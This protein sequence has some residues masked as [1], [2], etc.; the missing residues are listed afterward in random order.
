MLVMWR[1]P[2][3]DQT[4]VAVEAAQRGRARLVFDLDDL[5]IEPDLARHDLLDALRTER[6]TETQ[7]R[8]HYTRMRE[9]VEQATF[10]TASTNELAR[11]MRR[12]CKPTL[13]VPNGFDEATL[14]RSRSAVR[15]RRQA[16][17]D[18]LLR[19]GYAAG[20]RTHQRDFAQCVEAVGRILR[21]RPHCRLVLFYSHIDTFPV[22]DPGEFPALTGLELQ[23]EWR[24]TVPLDTM[25]DEM[26]RFDVNLAPLEAGNPFCEAKSELKF[27][28][29]ALVDVPTITA[30]TGPF[31]RAIDDGRTGCLAAT[32]D[33]WYAALARLLDDPALRRRMA[34]AAYLDVLY[35]N[36]PERRVELIASL[37]EQVR[38]DAPAARAFALDLQ[39]AARPRTPPVLPETTTLFA[40]DALGDAEVT[41]IVPLYN[42]AQYVEEALESVRMQSLAPLDLIVI[43][44]TSTDNS[45]DVARAWL[46]RN[47]AR[48][49]RVLL[50]RNAANAG[51]GVTRNAGFA[52]AE[53]P[54]VLPLDADDRLLPGCCEALLRARARERGRVRLSGDPP[55]RRGERAARRPALRARAADR[56]AVRACDVAGLR[57]RV[58]GGRRLRRCPAGLG[59]LRVLVPHG[60]MRH[61]RAAGSRRAA[62]RVSRPSRLH[63]LVG[64][65]D[66]C[67]QA[68]RGRGDP[69]AASVAFARRKRPC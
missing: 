7:A 19:L 3:N 44:D 36:G 59:G 2:L 64:D 66:G 16:P 15:A 63:A 22:L 26:A 46:E 6:V 24:A 42:Y 52:A 23:I 10:C 56:H 12:H 48:F 32:S 11:S 28:E 38:G 1:T 41:V 49:N 17:D 30:P 65:R 21:E 67:Q 57:R 35:R 68:A 40:A 18:G 53:T 55:V 51:L 61:A 9:M 54:Y 62:R 33:A 69:A 8:G 14:R 25:P 29:A 27:F 5:M 60:R 37:L 58:V 34:R 20:S 47:A 13:V 45:A 43:D 4:R 50:L 39:R 31:R